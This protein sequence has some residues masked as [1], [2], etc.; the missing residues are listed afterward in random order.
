MDEDR[1]MLVMTAVVPRA[2][3]PALAV[4]IHDHVVSVAG[5]GGYLRE[6]QLPDEAD[7]ELLDAQLY[8]DVLELRAPR[9][10]AGA[11]RSV[12]VRVLR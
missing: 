9:G 10:P 5:S 8:D 1:E 7:T 12:P 2:A 6:L 4:S 11:A 3:R